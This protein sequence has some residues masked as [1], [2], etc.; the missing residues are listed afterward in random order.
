MLVITKGTVSVL[1][2]VKKLN[3]DCRTVVFRMY[4]TS[5]DTRKKK[6]HTNVVNRIS[7]VAVK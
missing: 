7:T 6:S 2:I 5:R 4:H 1:S 3:L